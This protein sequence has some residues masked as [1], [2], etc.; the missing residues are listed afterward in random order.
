MDIIKT[1]IGQNL[2][3]DKKNNNSLRKIYTVDD[4]LDD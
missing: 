3:S 2:S 4:D 1:R